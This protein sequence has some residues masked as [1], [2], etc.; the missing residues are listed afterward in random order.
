[1]I[2]G[3]TLAVRA[4]DFADNS[5]LWNLRIQYCIDFSTKPG[6]CNFQSLDQAE[7][8]NATT[9]LAWFRGRRR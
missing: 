5:K 2:E 4:M 8:S 7:D 3:K 6:K 9:C 1:M